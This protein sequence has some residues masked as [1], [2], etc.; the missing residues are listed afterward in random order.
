MFPQGDYGDSLKLFRC[1]K[2]P[3]QW[4]FEREILFSKKLVDPF[5]FFKNGIWWILA[6]A[7]DPIMSGR[8]TQLEVYFSDDLLHGN[9]SP[10]PL[11]PVL[12]SDFGARNGGNFN[13]GNELFRVGQI[14]GSDT[15][16]FSYGVFKILDISKS[17][18]EEELQWSRF[19]LLG[20]K[21]HHLCVSNSGYQA[22]DYKQ[23]Y[24]TSLW[25]LRR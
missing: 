6:T 10:H 21:S 25:Y 7:R 20:E 8:A 18:F 2:F 17:N 19:N 24:F 11:N 3:D 13:I 16:G 14:Q 22:H 1:K 4:V 15:Y 5:C 9:F 23:H 12:W